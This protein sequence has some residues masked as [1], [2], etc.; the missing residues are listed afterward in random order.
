MTS[1]WLRLRRARPFAPFRGCLFVFHPADF[2]V[3]A[4]FQVNLL[5]GLTANINGGRMKVVDT[6]KSQAANLT[7]HGT[8][9][10]RDADAA[11]ATTNI[12]LTTRYMAED[13][14]RRA[15]QT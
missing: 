5:S 9:A 6:T 15:A 1:V 13:Q 4:N 3:I 8:N 7:V 2:S 12:P 14:A 11:I 10:A